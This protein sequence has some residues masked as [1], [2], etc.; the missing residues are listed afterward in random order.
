M[1]AAK[2][3]FAKQLYALGVDFETVSAARSV[4][5]VPGFVLIAFLSG[6]FRSEV[7][8]KPA[9]VA[10]AIGAGLVCYYFGSL[11][12][13][14]ALTLI[15]ASVERSLLF[16]YP[17]I[18]MVLGAVLGL[19]PIRKS[20]IAALF[21]TFVGITLV[22]GIDSAEVLNAN[23]EG[24]LWVFVCAITIAIYFMVSARLSPVMGSTMF[25]LLAMSAAGTA[26]GVHYSLRHGWMDLSL[27]SQ[28]WA[29]LVALILVATI[30]PLS[31]LGE[32]IRRIG[33]QRAA[34]AST[35]GPPSTAIMAAIF[36]NEQLTALQWLGIAIV[37][38]TIV[39]LEVT[40]RQHR[41]Q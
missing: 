24:A 22:V 34:F 11:V 6:S 12:N 3:I 31:L 21:M 19:A 10:S 32:G 39:Y 4:L 18:V 28:A 33:S 13:F 38:G 36:L 2:G 1:L 35:I 7:K 30:I 16:T 40:A 17:A 27:S 9:H 25:T 14:Y 41:R 23:L 37:S 5:A 8:L 20:A 15:D 29:W 26:F